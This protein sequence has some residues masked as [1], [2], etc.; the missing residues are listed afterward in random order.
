MKTLK[1]LMIAI[2]AV[3][4]AVACR[5]GIDDITPV[6]PEPDESAPE[7]TITYPKDGDLVQDS[8][9]VSPVEIKFTATDDIEIKEVVVSL[10][11]Q[12]I[13]KFTE[14]KDYRVFIKISIN[15]MWP[16]DLTHWW[17]LPQI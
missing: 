14:F 2:V 3:V 4:L 8:L 15:L 7:V 6:A 17:S 16:W 9:E 11:G 13:G 5:D 10:D 12:E 1:Y